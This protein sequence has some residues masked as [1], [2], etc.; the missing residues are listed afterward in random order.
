VADLD[1]RLELQ[2]PAAGRTAIT[3]LRLADIGEPRLEVA[4]ELDAAEVPARAVR[5]GDELATRERLVGDHLAV[6]ADGAERSGIRAE[7]RA[8]LVVAGRA[9]LLAHGGEE[10]GLLEPVVAAHERQ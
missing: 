2:R 3:L 5:A 9:Q 7:R 10:L 8:D 1:R 4:A 6:E